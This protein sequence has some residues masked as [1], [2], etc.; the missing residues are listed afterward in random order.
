MTTLTERANMHICCICGKEYN[1]YGN[2][3]YPVGWDIYSEDDRCCDE[4]NRKYVIPAR[5]A[6]LA[7]RDNK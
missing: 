3:P 1:G 7:E 6:K 2:N 5:I 4:C